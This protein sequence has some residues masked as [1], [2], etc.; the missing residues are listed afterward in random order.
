MNVISKS[1]RI[2]INRAAH[3]QALRH[4]MQLRDK[5]TAELSEAV[6]RK[7]SYD[8]LLA[9]LARLESGTASAAKQALTKTAEHGNA[10]SNGS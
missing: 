10:V 8:D 3:D 4:E 6:Q 7:A 5:W 2:R 1:F 9:T